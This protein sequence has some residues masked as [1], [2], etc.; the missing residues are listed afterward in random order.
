MMNNQTFYT[1]N[2]IT[3]ATAC[4]NA[5]QAAQ[6]D[7]L[8]QRFF[9]VEPIAPAQANPMMT[10][11]LVP[12]TSAQAASTAQTLIWSN[13]ESK[14]WKTPEGLCLQEGATYLSID[15]ARSH[16]E[17]MVDAEFWHQPLADQRDFFLRSLLTLLRRAEI[18]GL[19]ANGVMQNDKG[20]LLIGQ[21]G[22]GKTTLTLSLVQA[23]W[24]YLGDD[25][26]ALQQRE[27]L[28][29][30]LA[31]QHSFACTPQT[32]GFFPALE[33]SL[34]QILDPVRHKRQLT[35]A[36]THAEQFAAHCIPRV[37]LFPTITRASHSRLVALGET[38]AMLNL[39]AHSA[40]LLLDSPSAARQTA[41]LKQLAQQ[42]IAYQLLL[43]Q[44]VYAEPAA[45]VNLL[46]DL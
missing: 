39:M 12:T 4:A 24:H 22:S 44:D 19:H 14:V 8:W 5:A 40:G 16:A 35:L 46:G 26:V 43:G 1:W 36:A 18:Y 9:C 34:Q 37:L 21:S 23:G 25:V 3:L 45:I 13:G 10:L 42:A 15:I 32:I 28:V 11:Q 2:H 41:V 17:G 29:E 27:G 6:L 33:R 38:Q 30:A 20:I 31:L 7:Q